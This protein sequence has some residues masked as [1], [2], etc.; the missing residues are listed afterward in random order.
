[1]CGDAN[2]NSSAI[3]YDL[4]FGTL[5]NNIYL[6]GPFKWFV[7]QIWVEYVEKIINTSAK[8]KEKD[9]KTKFLDKYTNFN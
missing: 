5:V 6:T 3:K 7:R 1:M 4:K 2:C 8:K 9:E